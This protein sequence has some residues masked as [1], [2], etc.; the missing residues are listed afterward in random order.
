MHLPT[1][2]LSITATLLTPTLALVTNYGDLV[3]CFTLSTQD[4]CSSSPFLVHVPFGEACGTCTPVSAIPANSNHSGRAKSLSVTI[5][6][7]RC[8]VT[9]FQTTD[10]SDPGIV[11]GTGGCWSPE[12]GIAAYKVDCPWYPV[13]EEPRACGESVCEE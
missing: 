3:T 2:L 8:R 12:G 10:C 1:I 5:L 7:P 6:E 9:V 4:G 11:S 13:E